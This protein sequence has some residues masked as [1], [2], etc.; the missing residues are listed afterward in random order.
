[1]TGNF[2]QI[3]VDAVLLGMHEFEANVF[4]ACAY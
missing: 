3:V 4:D 2:G 1:M